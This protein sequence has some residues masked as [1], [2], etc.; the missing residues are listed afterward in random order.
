MYSRIPQG[1]SSISDYNLGP[2]GLVESIELIDVV[3]SNP[4]LVSADFRRQFRLQVESDRH[5][6]LR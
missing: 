3:Y 4:M 2:F 1:L 6:A 5:P